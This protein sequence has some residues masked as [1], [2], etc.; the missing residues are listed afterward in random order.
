[1]LVRRAGTD[2]ASD[3]AARGLRGS[4]RRRGAA[5]RRRCSWPASAGTGAR[6]PTSGGR[7]TS[8]AA[9]CTT[10]AQRGRHGPPAACAAVVRGARGAPRR[11]RRGSAGAAGQ[12]RGPRG[13]PR[14][15]ARSRST[16]GSS[17]GGVMEIDV[18]TLFPD[19]FAWF[20][21]QRHV[22][23]ALGRRSP[24][25]LR[26]LPRPHAAERRTGRRHAVRR[27]RREWCCGS[28][29]SRPRCA[30]RYGDRSGRA[31]APQRRV[32]ALT[33]GGRLLDDALVDELAAEPALTLLC[34]RYE[35]FDQRVLEHFASDQVS[36]GRYVLAGRRAGGDG[37]VRRRAAQAA[38]RAGARAV[39]AR[40]VLQRGA[41]TVRPSTRTTPGRPSTAAG[42][43]PEVLLSGHHAR[44]REWR[45]EQSRLRAQRRSA[46]SL[47]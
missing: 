30:A 15:D 47:P 18:F 25:R 37:G 44:I 32:I 41:R 5:R 14:S 12:R 22:A 38:R 23:N 46:G 27:R 34:G 13:R 19:A 39:G 3:R 35:G 24:P 29:S 1:M 6:A 9:P 28:M 11:R 7:R 42:G 36:I 4:L 2:R 45:L 31:R 10:P 33:P 16:S 17:G 43:V 26:Q 21:R 40:G 8:K 20:E